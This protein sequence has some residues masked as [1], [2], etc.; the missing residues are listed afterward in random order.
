MSRAIGYD[1]GWKRDVGYGVPAICDHPD[2]NKEIDRGFAYRC[3]GGLYGEEC[4]CGLFFCDEHRHI[5]D[6]NGKI[7]QLCERC[8]D[9]K[10]PFEP[11]PD[12]QEWCDWKKAD[13]GWAQWR[14]ENP[15]FEEMT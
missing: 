1:P 4:G 5:C 6:C 3:G 7:F 12:T 8:C 11:K 10:E 14:E 13:K 15:E 2:C 9:D